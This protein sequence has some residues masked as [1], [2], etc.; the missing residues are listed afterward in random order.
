M[1]VKELIEEAKKQKAINEIIRLLENIE[2]N[3]EKQEEWKKQYQ[4]LLEKDIDEVN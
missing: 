1:K 4:E 3:K 2:Y